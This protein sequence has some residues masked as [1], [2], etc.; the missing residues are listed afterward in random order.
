MSALEPGSSEEPTPTLGRRPS[1]ATSHTSTNGPS[2]YGRDGRKERRVPSITPRKFSRF[3]TPRSQNYCKRSSSRHA[4]YDIT[5]PINNR[6]GI[7]SSPLRPFQDMPGQE[8]GAIPFTREL[9]RRK[10]FHTPS[11]SPEKCSDRRNPP[12]IRED[13]TERDS[14]VPMSSPCAARQMDQD[15]DEDESVHVPVAPPKRIDT[16]EERGLAGQLLQLRL[17][18]SSRS[19]WQHMS[20]PAPSKLPRLMISMKQ[21]D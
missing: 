11:V 21:F 17:G 18:T 2:S 10:V 20:S 4:L 7:Q 8:N 1:D 6:N 14:S 3:F 5:A 16:F 13:D 15:S 19:T 12:H 9:K